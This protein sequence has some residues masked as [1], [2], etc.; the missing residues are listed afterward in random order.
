MKQHLGYWR[1]HGA[2]DNALQPP[3][4]IAAYHSTVT[5]AVQAGC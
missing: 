1:Q 3:L 5:V 4:L 2:N